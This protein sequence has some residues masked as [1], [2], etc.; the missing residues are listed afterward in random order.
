[1]TRRH[2]EPGIASSLTLRNRRRRVLRRADNE[3][4]RRI[5]ERTSGLRNEP[6]NLIPWGENVGCK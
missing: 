5:M 1:M 2:P 3:A 6:P 4:I